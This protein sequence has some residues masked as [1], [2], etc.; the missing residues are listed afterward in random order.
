VRRREFPLA[1][2]RMPHM[3]TRM[4][5]ITEN[6]IVVKAQI[7]HAHKV[8]RLARDGLNIGRLSSARS[9]EGKSNSDQ[10]Q[11]AFRVCYW[12]KHH[13]LNLRGIRQT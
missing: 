10:G 9:K 2:C 13:L 3:R 5:A 8:G 7:P 4:R 12:S 11:R 6:A 1:Q